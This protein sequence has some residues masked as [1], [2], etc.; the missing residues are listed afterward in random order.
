ME[1]AFSRWQMII[2]F[3]WEVSKPH[4]KLPQPKQP[5]GIWSQTK[6]SHLLTLP[7]IISGSNFFPTIHKKIMVVLWMRI[8]AKPFHFLD[9][10]RWCDTFITNHLLLSLMRIYMPYI[11]RIFQNLYCVKQ[12][13]IIITINDV[14]YR[15]DSGPKIGIRARINSWIE[16]ELIINSI[17]HSVKIAPKLEKSTDHGHKLISSE[18]GQDTSACKISGQSLHAFSGK[19]LETSPDGQTDKP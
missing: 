8:S 18:D 12:T 17:Q 16:L 6:T 11:I 9:W 10:Y 2:E 13:A 19:C 7:W 4:P 3:A 1:Q 5:H 15:C 14:V